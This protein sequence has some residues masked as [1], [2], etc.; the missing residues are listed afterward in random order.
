MW[1]LENK[2]LLLHIF[3]H[4]QHVLIDDKTIYLYLEETNH[5]TYVPAIKIGDNVKQYI[6][7]HRYVLEWSNENPKILTYPKH[8]NNVTD[9]LNYITHI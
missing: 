9:I 7:N 5:E 1:K 6:V 4:N 8:V 3:P 2:K